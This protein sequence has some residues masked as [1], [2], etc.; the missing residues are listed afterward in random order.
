MYGL[1]CQSTLYEHAT[2]VGPV[3]VAAATIAPVVTAVTPVVA[4]TVAVA[5][6]AV[7]EITADSHTKPPLK[8][9]EPILGRSCDICRATM[10]PAGYQCKPC[11]FDLE[12]GGGSVLTRLRV[13]YHQQTLLYNNWRRT[14]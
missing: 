10:A 1:L 11:G 5:P 3:P 7:T 8:W 12:R 4:A 2:P 14:N 13:L 9:T 6:V